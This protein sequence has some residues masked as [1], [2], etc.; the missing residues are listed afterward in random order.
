MKQ[1]KVNKLAV[2]LMSC[3]LVPLVNAEEGHK[4]KKSEPKL[5]VDIKLVDQSDKIKISYGVGV[6]IGR[7]FKRLDLDIDLETLVKGLKDANSGKK[8]ALSEDELRTVMSQ[9]QNDLKQK[10]ITAVKRISEENQKKGDAFLA[11]NA[12]KEGVISLPSGL[13]YTI[14]TK[15]E[16]K[17]PT[18]DDVV[19]CH[20]RGTLLDGTV[21]DSSAQTGK[22]AM[23][24]VGGVIP[25]WQEALK[26]MPVG[27][28]WQVFIPAQLA[29]GQR[30][31]GRDIAPNS[32]L[33]FE[34][35][36]LDVQ[37]GK[38]MPKNL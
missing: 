10:Q 36:L 14:L 5:M 29:Y 34:L 30:G 35:E 18:Q 20:Y 38:P 31:A 9:Y 15:G 17:I 1:K 28:K 12:K 37:P 27:S 4:P 23:F 32:T 11:E 6:D 8:L 3:A 2:F 13:Q 22:P 25:G 19:T 33:I 7:N 16:G 24:N 26:L 21:F